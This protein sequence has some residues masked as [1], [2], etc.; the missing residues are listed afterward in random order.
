[1]K[2]EPDEY[3]LLIGFGAALTSYLGLGIALW[4]VKPGVLFQVT[5][6]LFIFVVFL[7]VR[8]RRIERKLIA[9]RREAAA[10]ISEMEDLKALDGLAR[11]MLGLALYLKEPPRSDTRHH[12][13]FVK[14]EYIISHDDGLYV[15]TLDGYNATE[16]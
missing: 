15:W 7:T 2:T 10:T 3:R 5:Y 12:L 4:A 16:N 11:G 8:L 9:V 6:V 1:M 14:E 13:N